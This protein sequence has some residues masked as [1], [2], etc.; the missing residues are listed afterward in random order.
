[1]KINFTVQKL[2]LKTSIILQH[3]TTLL[4]RQNI[5]LTV[6]R[7]IICFF[8]SKYCR[9]RVKFSVQSCPSL[10]QKV[11]VFKVVCA[12]LVMTLT[13]Y[14]NIGFDI[15]ATTILQPYA[16]PGNRKPNIDCNSALKL[17]CVDNY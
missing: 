8:C 9:H 7:R 4:R 10:V 2:V 5:N 15:A 3:L 1:M 13:F 6:D 17:V 14:Y 16:T 11:L 12:D